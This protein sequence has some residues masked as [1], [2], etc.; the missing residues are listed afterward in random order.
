MPQ[1]L[2]PQPLIRLN[3]FRMRAAHYMQ[4]LGDHRTPSLLGNGTSA[5]FSHLF[6]IL[7]SKPTLS[8]DLAQLT[9]RWNGRFPYS[10]SV[11]P[12]IRSRKLMLDPYTELWT[13]AFWLQTHREWEIN[14]CKFYGQYFFI[15]CMLKWYFEYI[16]L[17][18]WLYLA[19]LLWK[20]TCVA[21]S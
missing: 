1:C 19:S 21:S 5:P 14:N 7:I 8:L 9:Q 3:T 18:K 6:I 20:V 11:L 10:R 13:K 15:D 4:M 17:R 2:G 12:S 16:A